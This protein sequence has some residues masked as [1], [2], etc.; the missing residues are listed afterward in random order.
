M[1]FSY[2]FETVET[3]QLDRLVSFVRAH[4]PGYRGY[5][6]WINKMRAEVAAGYKEAIIATSND[7]VIG[8]SIW[9]P[10]KALSELAEFKNLRVV[11]NG[12]SIA[13]FIAK[14]VEV[15]ARERGFWGII[16]DVRSNQPQ[17]VRF[18]VHLDYTP[19][20]TISLYESSEPD[21]IMVKLFYPTDATRN[22]KILNSQFFRH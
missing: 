20:K 3:R 8:T 4:N 1:S 17:I 5:Y 9:Q 18:M 19:I 22:E 16:C 13:R 11:E 10:H 15:E 12:R 14:Q 21:V 6:E 7:K 2:R